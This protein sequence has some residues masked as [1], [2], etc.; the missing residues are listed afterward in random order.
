[1]FLVINVVNL[2]VL[3]AGKAAPAPKPAPA[4]KAPVPKPAPAPKP[5]NPSQPPPRGGSGT[6]GT[7]GSSPGA[8]A[9]APEVL[10]LNWQFDSLSSAINAATHDEKVVFVYF[11]FNKDKEVFPANY[12]AKLQKLSDEKYI[13]AKVLVVTDK[14]KEGRVFI[15][16]GNDSFFKENKLALS[17]I[18]V[19]LDP[20]GNLMDKLSP[21][22]SAPKITPFME[23]AEKKYNSI[24]TD[25]NNRYE[26][27]DKMLSEIESTPEKDKEIREMKLIP[28]A[29]KILLSIANSDYE[30]YQAKD[31]AN[32]KLVEINKDGRTEYLKL[33]KEYGTLD[34]ELR[35]PKS[36]TP[37]LEKLM[38]IYKGLPIEQDIKDDMKDIK[39]G[40]IPEKVTSELE[41][42]VTP[43]ESKDEPKDDHQE[44]GHD[45]APPHEEHHGSDNK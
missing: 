22:M 12:D 13:F 28:E 20:Y 42:P 21:P 40:K 19:A 25:L 31:K 36:I 15:S 3:G 10:E 33:M 29:T 4:P 24:L 26:R 6:G 45:D 44:Q 1:M 11:Y 30:G 18:G 5:F 43:P 23:N 38:K 16:D 8:A 34:K 7:P 32:D 37:Q 14:D 41:K 2:E 17:Y 27:A 35:D 9:D 39:D